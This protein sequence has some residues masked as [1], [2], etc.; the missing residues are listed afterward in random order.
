MRLR[1]FLCINLLLL[2][3]CAA[4][5]VT[6]SPETYFKEG[7]DFYASGRYE[8]AIAQWKK[9]KE[10]FRSPEMTTV[11]ELKIA[12]AQFENSSYIEAAVSYEE[13][14]KLHPTH[15]KA[16]YA[17]YRLA[18]CNYNQIAGIDT[19]QNPVKNAAMLLETFLKTY[20]KSEYA[21]DASGKLAD[22]KLKQLQYEVYVAR[23]YLRTERYPS[24]I[25]RLEELFAA[26]PSSAASDEPLF[27]LGKAY[28]MTGQKD[29]GREVFNR[30]YKE[31]PSSKYVDDARAVME[32]NY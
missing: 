3:G 6:K 24:A 8:D 4:P 16:P 32:K 1:L 11:A 17:L 2:A 31:H 23:F 12:D 13:F 28:I 18:L 27:Y 15:E 5:T 22:C 14:R 19:D 10:S 20:P 9:V 21:P 7:E 29:K 25:K 30:L 26:I